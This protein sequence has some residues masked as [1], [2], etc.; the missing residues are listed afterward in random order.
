MRRRHRPVTIN[1]IP[2][3]QILR[4]GCDVP[5]AIAVWGLILLMIF[6]V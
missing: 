5:E 1:T 6:A 3:G 4:A 2:W